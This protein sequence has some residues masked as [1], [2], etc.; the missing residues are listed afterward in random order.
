MLICGVRLVGI[1]AATAPIIEQKHD[2]NC[3]RE[4]TRRASIAYIDD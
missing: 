1:V 4:R 3:N 2:D